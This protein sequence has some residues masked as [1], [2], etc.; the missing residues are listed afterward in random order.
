MI[1]V[2]CFK[3]FFFFFITSSFYPLWL[4]SNFISIFIF[5]LLFYYKINY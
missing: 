5:V 2:F 1:E 3:L 4:L